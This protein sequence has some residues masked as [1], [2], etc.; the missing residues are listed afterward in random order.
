MNF[1]EVHLA[2]RAIVQAAGRTRFSLSVHAAEYHPGRCDVAWKIYVPPK[3]G[4]NS[5]LLYES[6]DPATLLE[7]LKLS[8]GGEVGTPGLEPV[9]DPSTVDR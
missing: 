4:N 9:G 2:A 1:K 3:I 5:P 7:W 6:T 8:L